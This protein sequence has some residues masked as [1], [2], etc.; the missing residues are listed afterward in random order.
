MNALGFYAYLRMFRGEL[1]PTFRTP[2]GELVVHQLD[3]LL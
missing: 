3:H 1:P 2:R